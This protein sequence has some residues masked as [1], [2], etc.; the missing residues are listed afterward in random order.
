MSGGAIRREGTGDDLL[1]AW[2]SYRER[3]DSGPLDDFQSAERD[4]SSMA[5]VLLALSKLDECLLLLLFSP[6]L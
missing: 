6:H 5:C 1:Y 3:D 4:D 2:N